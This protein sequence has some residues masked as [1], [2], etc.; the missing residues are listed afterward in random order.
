[1]TVQKANFDKKG[2]KIS[3][4]KKPEIFIAL[5]SPI[6]LLPNFSPAESRVLPLL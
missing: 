1:M 5:I 4:P 2:E 3:D 6:D